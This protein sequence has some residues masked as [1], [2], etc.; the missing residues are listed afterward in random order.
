ME[1]PRTLLLLDYNHK[2]GFEIRTKHKEA[3]RQFHSYR[4][5]PIEALIARYRMGK[6]IV[7]QILGYPVLERARPTRTGRPKKLSDKQVDKAIE[8][9]SASWEDRILNWTHLRDELGL[10]CTPETL[11]TRLKQR[12]HYRYCREQCE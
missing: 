10:T 5:K 8:Y 2:P 11:E 7:L 9:L 12:G 3:I 4:G 6:T 1:P